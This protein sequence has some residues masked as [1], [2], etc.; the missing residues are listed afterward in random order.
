MPSTLRGNGDESLQD[1]VSAVGR[2]LVDE[3][4]LHY[5]MEAEV[6]GTALL[7]LKENPGSNISEAL[8][9]GYMEWDL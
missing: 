5:G 8:M 7:F 9:A 6:L 1:V 2:V 4:V 3:D